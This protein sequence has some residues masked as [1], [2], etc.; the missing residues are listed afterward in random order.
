M[1]NEWG[2]I[3][4]VGSKTVHSN[5]KVTRCW[6][7]RKNVTKKCSSTVISAR[8]FV[9]LTTPKIKTLIMFHIGSSLRVH[10]FAWMESCSGVTFVRVARK[11]VGRGILKAFSM[12]LVVNIYFSASFVWSIFW[13]FAWITLG[14]IFISIRHCFRGAFFSCSYL[15]VKVCTQLC[16]KNLQIEWRKVL[17][18]S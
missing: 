10:Q 1:S 6:S 9:I 8:N 13:L 5:T 15:F 3:G 2:L 7:M 12:F 16:W 4:F 18:S 17:I 11:F 14:F